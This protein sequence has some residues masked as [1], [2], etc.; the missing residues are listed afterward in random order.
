MNLFNNLLLPLLTLLLGGGC[1]W[2]ITAKSMRHQAQADAMAHFQ[3]VYKEM[4][5]DLRNEIDRLRTEVTTL[6]S[7]VD[8]NAR[9]ISKAAFYARNKAKDCGDCALIELFQL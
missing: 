3:T 5:S 7:D 8:K 9:I 2:L 1:S 4:I 6:R